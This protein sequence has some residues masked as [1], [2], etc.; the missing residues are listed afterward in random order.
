MLLEKL[1]QHANKIAFLIINLLLLG[2]GFSYVKNRN[3]EIPAES[4][5]KPKLSLAEA[6]L[7]QNAQDL[8]RV[9][10]ENRQKKI[11]EINANPK[12]ITVENQVEVVKTIPGVT[13]KVQVVS[14]APTSSKTTTTTTTPKKTTTKKTKT[15]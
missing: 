4:K 8:E 5:E 9:L 11:D 7:L 3:V 2:L 10:A 14:T 12:E 1:K 13:R 15:S 6:T